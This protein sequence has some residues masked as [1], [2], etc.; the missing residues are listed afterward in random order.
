[1]ELN[2]TYRLNPSFTCKITQENNLFLSVP[3]ESGFEAREDKD[4]LLEL[5][6]KLDGENTL[7]DIH[8]MLSLQGYDVDPED[9]IS[10]TND[11]L[12]KNIIK[13]Q[14]RSH[15]V[16]THNLT[17]DE[18]LKYDRQ[19]KNYVT[20]SGKNLQDGLNYQKS[21]KD[22][23]IAI[24]GVGG[25][26][27]YLS[28]SLV[29]MG[30]G[31]IKLIDKDE[32]ELS[33]TSRQMLFDETDIGKLKIEVARDKLAK[34]N[35]RTEI[36]T[37]NMFVGYNTKDELKEFISGT[38]LIVCCADMPR[39]EIQYIIDEISHELEIPWLAYGPFHFH[40]IFCGPLVVP[41]KT[42][43]YSEIFPKSNF[44]E[45]EKVNEINERIE[46]NIMDPFNG[47][48]SKVA[49]IEIMK[50]VTG[51]SECKVLNNRIIIDTENWS[52]ENYKAEI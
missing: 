19:I 13:K 41:N 4:F 49:S 7:G 45:N 40:K 32:I 48:A 50:F 3:S 26:G 22:Y 44:I 8:S 33:N 46:S 51:Y 5:I 42:P 11:L 30:V 16:E 29:A 9:L 28:Y 6:Y 20:L 37:K 35:P 34:V 18:L 52:I 24:I 2:I 43:R 27:S 10:I 23:S 17:S 14:Q 15:E 36:K 12:E 25:I 21:L 39:G 38:N 1:M 47:L 31:E